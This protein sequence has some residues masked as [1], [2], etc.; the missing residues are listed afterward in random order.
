MPE[1]KYSPTE[2]RYDS[3]INQMRAFNIPSKVTDE[4]AQGRKWLRRY[5]NVMVD[6]ASYIRSKDPK[7]KSLLSQAKQIE[8]KWDME[9]KYIKGGME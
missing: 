9:G 5:H 6:V 4:E 8:K 1:K 3:L 7:Y 2:R